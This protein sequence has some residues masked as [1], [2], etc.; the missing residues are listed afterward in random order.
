MWH[1]E[2]RGIGSQSGVAM[3]SWV[4]IEAAAF[5]AGSRSNERLPSLPAPP[6][7]IVQRDDKKVA[8]SCVVN[9]RSDGRM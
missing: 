2:L 7:N 8:M 1:W 6:V 9:G 5:A 3:Q 4:T